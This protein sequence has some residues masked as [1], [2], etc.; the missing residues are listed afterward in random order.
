MEKLL[1]WEA[2]Q[3]D[4]NKTFGFQTDKCLYQSILQ[5]H[6]FVNPFLRLL[7]DGSSRSSFK[8]C[9]YLQ[10]K[11]TPLPPCKKKQ[12][13]IRSILQEEFTLLYV[14]PL[15]ACYYCGSLWGLLLIQRRKLQDELFAGERTL[16]A[17]AALRGWLNIAAHIFH[18]CPFLFSPRLY[19]Y[20]H[21]LQPE[22]TAIII[23]LT[24]LKTAI[25]AFSR[26]V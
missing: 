13:T 23:V 15:Y 6:L 7:A 14:I 21:S 12:K 24:S 4:N 3:H 11:T 9:A 22:A 2:R 10:R 26:S 5:R 1:F 18:K 25:R 8:N 16:V 19:F 17:K 20:R